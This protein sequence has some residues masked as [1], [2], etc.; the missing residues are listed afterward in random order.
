MLSDN[1]LIIR[2]ATASDISALADILDCATQK[3]LAKGVQQWEY[4]WDKTVIQGYVEKN[5][6]Y[7]ALW[8]GAPCGCFGL[9][10]YVP[11]RF[12]PQDTDGEYWYH[13]AVHPEYD[14]LG[15]G[16]MLC[17][18]VQKYSRQTGITIYFDCWAGNKSLR[19]YYSFNGFEHIGDFPEEDYF[20]SAFRY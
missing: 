5:E 10:K 11:N 19:N 2:K 18:W 20:V 9:K 15:I 3:L 12:V 13:L 17:R 16:Y 14:K 4:P 6:F 7:I 8:D 1:K